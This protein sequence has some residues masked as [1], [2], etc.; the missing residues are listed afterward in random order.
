MTEPAPLGERRDESGFATP[1]ALVLSLAIVIVVGAGMA[2][3]VIGLRT[4]DA[5]FSKVRSI[6][7]LEG[8]EQLAIEALLESPQSVRLRWTVPSPV[9]AVEVLA[10]P[11]EAKLNLGAAATLKSDDLVR[12]GSTDPDKAAATLTE[13][14]RSTS[15][16]ATSIIEADLSPIWKAC[17][18][19]VISPFGRASELH[20]WPA[21]T[22]PRRSIGSRLGA[23]WRL[24]ARTW[25]GW[26]DDRIVRLS[27]Y[28]WYPALIVE[29]RFFRTKMVG[30]PCERLI[31]KP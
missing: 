4:A 10:E 12:I 17:V 31:E 18:G 23:Y 8:A 9:G 22:V 6:Y 2:R 25:D 5:H 1:A 21:N 26:T 29:R 7:A 28:R 24:R 30:E 15:P 3:A 11:E 13:L 16:S 20:L 14:S 27:E 19:S